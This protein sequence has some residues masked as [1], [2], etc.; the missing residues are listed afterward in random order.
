VYDTRV[1]MEQ[2]KLFERSLRA[3]NAD[4]DSYY[5]TR[6]GHG[7]GSQEGWLDFFGKMDAF[8]QKYVPAS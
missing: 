7:F 1:D 3:A 5:Y 4:F 6:G 2:I 8:I